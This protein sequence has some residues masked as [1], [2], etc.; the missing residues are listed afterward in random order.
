LKVAATAKLDGAIYASPL[1]L[2]DATG[3]LVIAATE[4]NTVYA[5][6][7]DGS[8]VWS[9]HIGTP[10]DGSTLPCGNINPSGITGTPVYDPASGLVFA[11]AF[12]SGHKH[13]LVAVDAETGAVAWTRPVD[14]PGST[15][16]VE[17]QRGALLLSGGRVWIAYGGLY[18]DCG[19]YHGY[20]VGIATNGQGD[21][22]IYRDPTTREGGFWAPTGPAANS[23]GHL[24][25]P[26]G[27]GAAMTADAKYDMS[28]GVIALDG[29]AKVVSYFAPTQWR[30]DNAS[31]FGTTGVVLLPDGTAFINGK[32]G[33]AYLLKQGAL[34]GITSS[35]P[36]IA[37]CR[38]FG[39][40]T[41]A[42]GLVYVPCTDGLRAVRISGTSLSVA[43]HATPP[44][45]AVVGGGVVLAPDAHAGELYALDPA[46]GTVKAKL[47]LGD[48]T[49]RFATAAFGDDGHAYIGTQNGKL[50]IVATS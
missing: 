25:V 13:E 42:N 48:T 44:G 12:L 14:A 10:V 23:A 5:L 28:D 37:V 20:L 19:P 40:P 21:A 8:V 17:Q 38:A 41:Y 43:W 24:C 15:P 3:P 36:N 39:G 33:I 47:A 2:R 27:N 29:N 34:G 32:S 50:V 11:V 16:T 6:R 26:V 9:R 31:D 49:T 18:G 35:A 4:N 22:T 1:V 30:S 45:S 7:N 46:T